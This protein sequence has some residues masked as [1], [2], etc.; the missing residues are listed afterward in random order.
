MVVVHSQPRAHRSL[1]VGRISHRN[2]RSKI[3]F[4]HGPVRFS[5]A[6]LAGGCEREFR[7]VA[8]TLR[9][10]NG[11]IVKPLVQIDCGGYL[12]TI[13]FVGR[14]QQGV[15]QPDGDREIGLYTPGVLHI[16][17]KFVGFEVTLDHGSGRQ[18]R[19]AGCACNPVV[20]VNVDGAQ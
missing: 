6:A 3:K 19:G 9:C 5:P 8:Q 14:L 15:P 2:A 13:H 4:I 20:I 10:S 1:G 7:L 18:Q 12:L 17:L 11:A 16:P